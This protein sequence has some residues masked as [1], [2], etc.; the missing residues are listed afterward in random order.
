MSKQHHFAREAAASLVKL[1]KTTSNW[2][3]AA[4]YLDRAAA[5]KDRADHS[6]EGAPKGASDA[7]SEN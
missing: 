1:A 5:L 3:V 4:A 7:Q 6:P 2:Q